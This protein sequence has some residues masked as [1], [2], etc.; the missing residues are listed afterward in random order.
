MSK[1]DYY[2]VLGLAKS[3]SPDEIKK[4]YRKLAVKYHPDKNPG[5]SESESKFKEASEAYEVLADPQKRQTYDQF[6]FAGL[7]GMGE[8]GG[9]GG[10]T[11]DYEDIFGDFGDIFG[12]FFGNSGRSRTRRSREPGHAPGSDLRYDLEIPFTTAAFGDKIEIEYSKQ[13]H[14]ST[15]KGS[16][17]ESGGGFTTCHTCGGSGQVRRSSGFFS[18]AQPCPSCGG[19]G[20]VIDKPCKSCGG[21]G[22]SQKRQRIKVTI[23]AGIEHGKRI[24]I[25][26][27]GDAGKNGGPSG[28][29]YVYIIVRPHEFFERKGN[30]IYCAIPISPAQAALG[31][32]ISVET[33]D[34]KRVKV[35][36]PVATQNGKMLRIRS[37]GVPYLH[38]TTRRGD[39][40]IQ[41]RVQ[42]PAKLSGKQKKLYQEL[43]DQEDTDRKPK[44]LAL[45]DLD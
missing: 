40:Y 21:N 44:P 9:F 5:D 43:L 15:C 8:G 19:S 3:A 27:Q 23:P 10:S 45:K 13:V 36:V 32:E 18:I 39:M 26:G 25:P 6:G 16:G 41:F 17:A 22:L 2:E 24:H 42:T 33:L 4:A 38:S 28:D 30:D 14:C 20:S 12:S 37:E 31:D 35:K 1:R 34:G 29:L 11:R 7:E